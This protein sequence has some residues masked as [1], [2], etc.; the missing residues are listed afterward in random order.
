MNMK[1]YKN[2][3]ISYFFIFLFLGLTVTGLADY[4][5]QQNCDRTFNKEKQKE[6]QGRGDMH[7]LKD[8]DGIGCPVHSFS[9]EE[10]TK[11]ALDNNFD[12]QLTKYDAWIAR[13]KKGVAESVYDTVIDMEVKY[14][15]DQSKSTSTLLGTKS[16]DN[17]YN[18]GF[19]KKTPIGTTLSVDMTNNRNWSDSSAVTLSPSH[20][21]TL[22]LTIEQDLGKNFFGL[23][24]RGEIKITK[25]DIENSEY[26]S[27][28]K[29]EEDIAKVQKAYWDLVLSYNHFE[30]QKDMVQYAKNFYDLHQEKL[31]DGLVEMP[32]AIASEAHYKNSLN[33]L[34]KA[35]NIVESKINVLK[36]LLNI[37]DRSAKII[38]IDDFFLSE[39]DQQLEESLK[40]AFMC[41]PDYK[42]TLNDI[43]SKNIYVEMK[44]NNIW[45]EV[46]LKASF[47]RNGIADHFKHA[48]R[49]ISKEDNPDFFAGITISFP[50]E[51]NEAKSQFKKAELEKAK[52]L[53]EIKSL[54]R[55]ITIGIIDQVRSC[56]VLRELAFNNEAIADLQQQ[57]LKEEE[58]R[59][60]R[61]RSNTD[62][63]I[64]YQEDFLEAQFLASKAMFEFYTSIVDLR[65]KEG[66]L[67]NLYWEGDL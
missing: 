37:S 13:T 50:L 11:L 58:K 20:D 35:R 14:R 18:L 19:S 10:V 47:A 43:K 41:R 15:N 40:Q 59:F 33:D 44:E 52:A 25:I 30:I 53:L 32:E 60:N 66:T 1:T 31:K 54:E 46:N 65:C 8:I 7:W 39:E 6:S 61:G 38:P 17:D 5:T 26:S 16:V 34:L 22:E 56:N 64:R 42:K 55:K 24:D 21:S 3:F 45:P 28:E 4:N 62:T 49:Q 29:I 27:L 51:N 23:Q 48:V 2:Y 9:L 63:I 57:K 36:L 67:L 12:I